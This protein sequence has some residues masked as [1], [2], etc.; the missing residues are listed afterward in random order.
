MI[1]AQAMISP[2]GPA[3]ACLDRV[4]AGDLRLVWSDYVL[5]EIRELPTKLPPRLNATP[6][7][8]EAFIASIAPIAVH[9]GKVTDIYRNP[10]D[11]DDSHYVNLALASGAN[12]ITSRDADLLR[13]MDQ[14]RAEAREF[15]ERFPGLQILPPEKILEMLRKG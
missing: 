3:A 1:Y 2:T 10:F 7:R 15:C 4:R 9:I 5:H 14:T 11:V 8:V 6:E 12:L 13:L